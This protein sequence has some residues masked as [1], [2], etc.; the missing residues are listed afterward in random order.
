LRR[1]LGE[2]W[3]FGEESRYVRNKGLN[4]QI[5][6]HKFIVRALDYQSQILM[7]NRR[8]IGGK[9]AFGQKPIQRYIQSPKV[10]ISSH[11]PV[12][13]MIGNPKSSIFLGHFRERRL[14]HETIVQNEIWLEE[15][16]MT[17]VFWLMDYISG[18]RLSPERP[19]CVHNPKLRDMGDGGIMQ[20]R[21]C[22]IPIPCVPVFRARSGHIGYKIEGGAWVLMVE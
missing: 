8:M 13:A 21:I 10:N 4:L 1:P 11:I 3:K 16:P 20:V 18:A 15:V 17:C 5:T 12:I 2:A 9:P 6:Q 22:R 14:T 7:E 19:Y